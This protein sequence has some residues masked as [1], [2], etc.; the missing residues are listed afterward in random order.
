MKELF[1]QLEYAKKSVLWLL[2]HESGLVDMHDLTYWAERVRQIRKEIIA[3]LQK[4]RFIM[5][6]KGKWEVV[7]RF[8]GH[9]GLPVES[10]NGVVI[11][12]VYFQHMASSWKEENWERP[13]N[14][15]TVANAKLIAAAPALLEA[16]K[17]VLAIAKENEEDDFGRL[18]A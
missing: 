8:S 4:E 14:A 15:E 12:N 7:Y 11:A 6:T 10:E 3:K 2:D 17:K 13:E 5:I 16:C 9:C 1:E 18:Q